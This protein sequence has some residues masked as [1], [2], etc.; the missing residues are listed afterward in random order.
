MIENYAAVYFNR[1]RQIMLAEA[2][3]KMVTMQ[4]F[5]KNEAVL[6][7][8]DEV[9]TLLQQ[10]TNGLGIKS[11]SDG[12]HIA[13]LEPV[14]EIIGPYAEFAHLESVYLG[15][16]AQQTK[17]ATNMSN[18][19]TAAA[20]KPVLFFGDRFDNFANQVNNGYAAYVG[21][22]NGFATQA[23]VSKFN[24]E[25]TGTMP[26]ALIAAFDGDVVAASRAFRKH[27]PDVPLI[28][29]V[30][31]N[32]D[33]VTDSIRCLDAFGKD[34]AGVRLDTSEKLIDTSLELA[35][36]A[37]SLDIDS[38]ARWQGV[39]PALVN[40]VRQGL[41]RYGGQHVKI[42]VSGGFTANKVR[43]FESGSVPVDV[44]AV[45]SSI[46]Q[47]SNDFTADIVRPT[48]KVGREYRDSSRLVAR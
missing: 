28:A 12:D 20:G 7:G 19:V 9:V 39:C 35:A 22:A 47:G 24:G 38:P 41:D 15:I 11:L 46:I 1:A 26:H 42:V 2:P 34:L 21:G 33:C 25:A 31:F 6:C 10:Q 18:V 32:N 4:V 14:L 27:F 37:H 44:Y 29:L 23:M 30:D 17:V 43:A 45:G 16:L 36:K 5:Q 40:N 13:P 8:I 48:V 3:G